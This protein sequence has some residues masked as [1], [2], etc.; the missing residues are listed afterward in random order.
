MS[1]S[2]LVIRIVYASF[3]GVTLLGMVFL[4]ILPMP[5]SRN[6]YKSEF[7]EGDQEKLSYFQ[8]ISKAF[9]KLQKFSFLENTFKLLLTRRMLFA[10]VAFAYSG[11]ELSFWSGIYPSCVA[12]TTKL[13]TDTTTKLALTV[14]FVGLGHSVGIFKFFNFLALISRWIRNRT[15]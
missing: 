3:A 8:V 11:I 14:L 9:S 5:K 7:Y 15:S 2:V 10:S 4:S 1:L 12:F 13:D 6:I